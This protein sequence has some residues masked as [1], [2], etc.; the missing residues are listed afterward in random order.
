MS[1]RTSGVTAVSTSET[2]DHERDGSHSGLKRGREGSIKNSV[3][4]VGDVVSGVVIEVTEA[5]L[6]IRI[7]ALRRGCDR[8]SPIVAFGEDIPKQE[9]LRARL[10][11]THLSDHPT[12]AKFLAEKL[13]VG[14]TIPSALV[15]AAFG[16]GKNVT[17]RKKRARAAATDTSAGSAGSPIASVVH[18]LIITMKPAI[19]EAACTG[20]K[21]M[22]P[23][24]IEDVVIDGVATGYV[25]GISS[26]GVFVRF[27]GAFTALA[28]RANISD[29]W[30]ADPNE[31]CVVGQTVR[32]KFVEVDTTKRRAVGTLK[33]SVVGMGGPLFLH[34]L[35]AE[36][37]LI[38]SNGASTLRGISI[39]SIITAR[40]SQVYEYGL[41]LVLGEFVATISD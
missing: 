2:S 26:F 9:R 6:T 23:S 24:R 16:D 21:L 7:D 13:S 11:I 28:P 40:L 18:S 12:H 33:P 19:L 29:V 30:I 32:M 34:S 36:R 31:C 3:P 27:L 15:L 38:F 4:G 20:N 25:C 5:A 35:M 41:A 1:F 22:L 10:E 37:Q 8:N 17:S 39:G 14:S